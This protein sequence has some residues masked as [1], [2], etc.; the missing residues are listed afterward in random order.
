MSGYCRPICT[1]LSGMY[2]EE[3]SFRTVYFWFFL[4]IFPLS[5]IRCELSDVACF[6]VS[7]DG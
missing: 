6:Y 3:L 5:F 1:A 4:A 2:A 7:G